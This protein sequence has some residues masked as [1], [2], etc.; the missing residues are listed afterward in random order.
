MAQR[1]VPIMHWPI[2]IFLPLLMI[3]VGILSSFIATTA[4]VI[5]FIKLVNELD[6]M[7]KIDKAKVLLP[8]SF[9]GILGGSCTLMGTSTNLIVSGISNKSGIGK[10]SFFEFSLAGVIFLLI[11]IP[12]VFLLSKLFLPELACV[13]GAPGTWYSSIMSVSERR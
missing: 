13:L 11:A 7:G 12:I 8:I 6:K 5:I 4:V 9:A 2:W 10:F 3:A 1:I